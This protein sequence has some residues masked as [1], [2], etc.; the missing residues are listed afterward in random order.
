MLSPRYIRKGRAALCEIDQ[1]ALCAGRP[2]RATPAH[3]RILGPAAA[4]A[5]SAGEAQTLR[6]RLTHFETS[7][8][9][10]VQLLRKYIAYAREFCRPRLSPA[11]KGV[12]KAFYLDV[13]SQ[14]S[15]S[16]GLAVNVRLPLLCFVSS[17]PL[18][19]LR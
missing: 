19:L 4:A 12:L 5:A 13:R 6:E 9:L 17:R 3:A 8:P 16:R 10:P 11:A 14:T 2:A 18:N 15:Q 1:P 7:N